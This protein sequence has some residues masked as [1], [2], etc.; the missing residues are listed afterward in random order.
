M[1]TLSEQLL[2]DALAD[3]WKRYGVDTTYLTAPEL[4]YIQLENWFHI[5]NLFIVVELNRIISIAAN[6]IALITI[7]NESIVR[8]SI[9][10]W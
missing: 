4:I 5:L 9:T 3:D 1:M 8:S 10:I 6:A 7:E 2:A